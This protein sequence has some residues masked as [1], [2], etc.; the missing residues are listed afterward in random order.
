MW[1]ARTR[2]AP[3]LLMGAVGPPVTRPA[4]SPSTAVAASMPKAMALIGGWRDTGRDPVP[5]R[6]ARRGTITKE[7]PWAMSTSCTR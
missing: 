7:R 2:L 1:E 5:G 3:V 4:A 6:P